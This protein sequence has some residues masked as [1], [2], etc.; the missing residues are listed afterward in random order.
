MIIKNEFY[1]LKWQIMT[2]LFIII[3]NNFTYYLNIYILIFIKYKK[4]FFDLINIIF[5]FFGIKFILL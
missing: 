4:M 1:L 3:I 5:H 2:K